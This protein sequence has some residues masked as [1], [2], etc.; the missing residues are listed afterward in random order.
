LDLKAKAGNQE[1]TFQVQGL[2]PGA[3]KLWI[4]WI[5]LVQPHLV[6]VLGDGVIAEVAKH[7]AHVVA[8]QVDPFESKP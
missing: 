3:F 7:V 8:A 6:A 1:I 2:K 5:Q 4:N